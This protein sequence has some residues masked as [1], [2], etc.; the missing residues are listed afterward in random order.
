MPK[1]RAEVT[2]L[3]PSTPIDQALHQ[4][5]ARLVKW[6]EDGTLVP[7]STLADAWGI[8]RQSLAAVRKRNEVFSFFIRGQHWYTAEALKFD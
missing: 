7:S 2:R 1:L 5:E 4:G 6:T 3:D 8:Q